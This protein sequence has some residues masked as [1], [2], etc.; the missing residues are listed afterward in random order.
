MKKL[1][2]YIGILF[3]AFGSIN[4]NAQK[5]IRL[6]DTEH[7]DGNENEIPGAVVFTGDVQFEHNGA[8]IWCNKAY[9][10]EQENYAK[11]FGDVRIIQGDTIHMNSEY[12]EYNGNKNF[13]FASGDVVMKSP[14]MRLTTDTLYFDR[15]SQQAYYNSYGTIVNED[16]TLK[17]KSGR[18]YIN[19]KKYQFLTAVT[20][21]NPKYVLKS[22]HLDYYTDS[23]LA[24]LYG[25][26]TIT[27]T[28]NENKLYSEKGFYNTK[29]DISYF[30]KNAK[31]FLKERTVEGDSLYY[32]KNKGFASATNNIKVIDTVQNLVTK[33]NYA[34]IFEHKDSL[35][36]VKRAVAISIID[37]DSMFV[38]GDTILVTGK[39]EKRIIRT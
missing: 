39:P 22:N 3:I 37:K 33:S 12:A 36:L 11:L 8:T 25:P 6:I 35:F 18:Y 23:G 21:T 2:I 10:F 9:L 15:A 24:Y 29:T 20:L 7:L 32:D 17:S 30:T 19:Q 4:A 26:S 5:K 14:D 31:L 1:L 13:A 38:H 27:N 16:N 34:E 28:Q